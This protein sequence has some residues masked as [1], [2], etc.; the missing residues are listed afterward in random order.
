MSLSS[1]NVFRN[2][3][4]DDFPLKRKKNEEKNLIMGKLV[5]NIKNKLNISF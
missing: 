4:L 3:N 2:R 1:H 5:Q